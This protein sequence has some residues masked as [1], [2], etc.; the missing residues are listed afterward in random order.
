MEKK[1]IIK[2]LIGIF[3]GALVFL[4]TGF[5]FDSL[6]KSKHIIFLGI[7]DL[8]GIYSRYLS[9]PYFKKIGGN[10]T[11]DSSIDFDLDSEYYSI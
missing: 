7:K 3:L 11:M 9:I 4:G 1:S 2:L 6:S 5:Y 10:F 8:N